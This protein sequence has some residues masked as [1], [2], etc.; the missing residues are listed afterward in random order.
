MNPIG[1]YAR[2]A[3]VYD[4][5]YTEM[6]DYQSH[7]SKIHAL[8]QERRLRWRGLTERW[9]PTS[10]KIGRHLSP[11]PNTGRRSLLQDSVSNT[12]QRD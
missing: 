10:R 7:A 6:I 2:S 4:A 5:I 9:M 12:I 1:P 8:I 11:T 3:A